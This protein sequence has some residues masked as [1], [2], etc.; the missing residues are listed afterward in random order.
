METEN[1]I[2]KQLEAAVAARQDSLEDLRGRLEKLIAPIP[3]GVVLADDQGKIGEIRR[4]CTGASQWSNRTWMVTLKGKG[5][6][7]QNGKLVTETCARSYFDG[8][9]MHHH[10]TEPFCLCADMDDIYDRP[11]L[12][13]LSGRETRALALRLPRA[14]ARYIEECKAEAEANEN[15]AEAIANQN[16]AV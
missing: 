3:V 2:I 5:L 13:W 10:S 11:K 8:Q 1:T 4:V 14:I 15:T 16:G 9:N 7:A 12:S 6:I